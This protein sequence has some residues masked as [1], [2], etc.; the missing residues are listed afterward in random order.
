MAAGVKLTEAQWR[1]L[2]RTLADQDDKGAI[3]YG[4]E[5]RTA[6]ALVR[7]GFVTTDEYR[8]WHV[9]TPAGRAYLEGN[10]EG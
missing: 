4:P 6:K 2:A 8:C 9:A 10:N 5:V 3:P 1:F 7:L